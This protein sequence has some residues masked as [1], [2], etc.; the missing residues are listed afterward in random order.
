MSD[1]PLWHST[2]RL[3]PF[4]L[5][6]CTSSIPLCSIPDSAIKKRLK[7]YDHRAPFEPVLYSDPYQCVC[8][9]FRSYTPG[10]TGLWST[11][12][13]LTQCWRAISEVPIK[14]RHFRSRS[15]EHR[16]DCTIST[17][18]W[19]AGERSLKW[20]GGGWG[21]K[22][23]LCPA[24]IWKI[25]AALCSSL[26]FYYVVCSVS[27]L[28]MDV[29]EHHWCRMKNI[30]HE[31]LDQLF[32]RPALTLSSFSITIHVPLQRNSFIIDRLLSF[33]IIWPRAAP[34]R[35]NY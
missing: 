30:E 32:T 10:Q 8:S 29:M 12:L 25:E 35:E 22:M 15:S 6:S 2:C 7:F 3:D 13:T 9:L 18:V 34:W 31:S 1:A 27:A 26:W 24:S 17:A 20:P 16:A 28:V 21:V 23:F 11:L 19:H 14:I 33:S 5:Q 4:L